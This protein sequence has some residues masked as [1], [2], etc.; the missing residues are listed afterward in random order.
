M[1][2]SPTHLLSLFHLT[3]LIDTKRSLTL[4]SQAGADLVAGLVQLL[5]VEG[6]AETDGG[7]SVELGAVG[8]SGDT[9]VVDLGLN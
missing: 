3:H 4:E 7:A 1:S 2:E 9:A 5:G 6:E 8:E